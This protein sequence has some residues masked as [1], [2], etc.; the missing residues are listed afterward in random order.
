[1]TMP[2][3]PVGR[4]SYQYIFEPDPKDKFARFK[5]KIVF[6]AGADLADMRDAHDAALDEKWPKKKPRGM[7]V[8]F[9]TGESFDNP[10]YKPDDIVVGFS[11][12]H[13]IKV[14]DLSLE[15]LG[16]EDVYSGMWAR[17]TW[18]CWAYDNESKG[19]GFGMR[20]MMKVKDDKAFG[21]SGT[22]NPAEDFAAF[23]TAGTGEDMFK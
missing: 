6:P 15:E 12:K 11:S 22:S 19:V 3:T 23:A 18:T 20:S 14:V 4:L 9:R 17:V 13:Q 7:N 16:A 10:D 1:M 5:T 2:I 8:T 21:G